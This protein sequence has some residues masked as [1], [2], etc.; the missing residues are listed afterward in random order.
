MPQL[1][2]KGT[3]KSARTQSSLFSFFTTPK[4]NKQKAADRDSQDALLDQADELMDEDMLDEVE[5]A[6]KLMSTPC[7]R[8]RKAAV[9][10]ADNDMDVDDPLGNSCS[11][12]GDDD[13]DD[14]YKP[15]TVP[16]SQSRNGRS[17]RRIVEDS[18]DE[19]EMQP[20]QTPT[21]SR[22]SKVSS[23][24]SAKTPTIARMR[25]SNAGSSATSEDLPLMSSLGPKSRPALL[26]TSTSTLST[27]ST[28]SIPLMQQLQSPPRTPT[29]AK[30]ARA[31]AFAKK[32]EERYAWLEDPRDAQGLRPGDSGYDKRTLL[33]PKAAWDKFSP[34]ERQ[35]W[36]IKCQHWDTVVFFKKGKF[37]E[38]YENDATIAHQDF[39]LKMTD[40]VNMRMA[41]V[42]ESSFDHWVAQFLAKG[43]RVARVDQKESRLAKE[44][45]ERGSTKKGDS[46]VLRELTGVLTAGTLVDPS[47]LTQDLATYCM[48]LVEEIH[49]DTS[50]GMPV[51]SFGVAFVDTSTAQF[52]LC[53][54]VDDDADRSGLETL[55]VQINP[56]EVVYVRGGAG[57]GT[58]AR[59]CSVEDAILTSPDA[60]DGMAGIS[61]ATW[62]VLKHTCA[63]TTDWISMAP[64]SE[65]WD[66][67]ASRR[68]IDNASYFE[69]WPEALQ[70]AADKQPL[71]LSAVGG[72]LSYL[73]TLKLDNDLASLGNF[74]FYS[75]M[76]HS[77]ALVLDG[78]SLANLDIFRVS[79]EG[80]SGST[81]GHA[82]EDGTLFA[83]LNHAR[84]PFGRRLLNRWIC[85]PLRH[86]SAI[87]ARLDAVEFLMG[88]VGDTI[89]EMLAGLPDL[90]R[91]LSR[92]HA[93]RCKVP[94][95]LSMLTGLGVASSIVKHLCELRSS[96]LPA[97]VQT[98]TTIFPELDE[99]LAEFKSAF[100][101]SVAETES[102]LLPF[103]GS[104]APY[105]EASATV[106]E[107][108]QWLDQHLREVC[109]RVGCKNITYRH[110][111][112]EQYQLEV[113][114]SVEVPSSYFMLSGT[115]AV[116]RYWSPE[117]RAKVQQR[118]E[119][120][121]T[122][123][124]VLDSY[125]AR[126]YSS[127]DRHY[128][129]TMKAVSVIAEIDCLLALATASRALGAPAC[130]PTVLD[131]TSAGGYIEFRQLRHPCV[132]LGGATDFVANDIVL[133]RRQ[134]AVANGT[135]AGQQDSAANEKRT[136]PQHDDPAS[137]I[138][139]TG[140][141]MGGKSTLLRQLCLGV[142]MAQIGCHVPAQ[143]AVITPVD[144][145]FTRIGA[146]DSLLAG[147]STFM[148]EMAET[149]AIVR[150]ATPRSLV[151]LDELG[152][153]TST[154]DGEAVAFAVL[155]TLCARL[156]C[157][158][159]FSTHYGLLAD[160]LL[161][162]SVEPHLRPMHMAC[163]VDEREH[164]VT[165]LY[166]LQHGIASKSHGMNVAAMAG[167]PTSIV[168]R[169]SAVAEQFEQR[170][171][172]K[173]RDGG[174]G[175]DCLPLALQSD[176]ANLMRV[177]ALAS[178]PPAVPDTHGPELPVG[179]TVCAKKANENQFWSCIVDHM[180]RTMPQL[181]NQHN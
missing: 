163:A 60:R 13:A 49:E 66:V 103:E 98:L 67:P 143:S 3:P 100:D 76:Q 131:D 41:G 62:R 9:V 27:A 151:V 126:L 172:L 177:A 130:R 148:V 86:A 51:T 94:D 92:I 119:A 174:A 28:S 24:T 133:G 155:H 59:S 135:T 157:L 72:L 144:R 179:G 171:K 32:N 123:T 122:R 109:K 56:R 181:D 127:F 101:M 132:A 12:D 165:F 38:L 1:D 2:S 65:F 116:R 96:A 70:T 111:G 137:M 7:G 50:T 25:Y 47:L 45:R 146:R 73:R 168:D 11:D 79:A 17:R 176:F 114:I 125:Q 44:M 175:T 167:V 64:R 10:D 120:V 113:P 29:E 118:A 31:S 39:D 160:A 142:I 6:E 61:Q 89:V 14:D 43:Y 117:L 102:R 110:I 152:R 105:D 99:L 104:D 69:A 169:A 35:Y 57:F 128:G 164:R 42:P 85:H 97:R 26:R 129:V 63:A 40:R 140:P 115:K 145:L 84:T 180:L 78:P 158:G 55:L 15:E 77:T 108:D 136:G 18:D 74:S 4:K 124:M 90:E 88:D 16:A 166:R 93:G 95:F 150:H 37:Y 46:L 156:G 134:D 154:H 36:E 147:R 30:R 8:K 20:P 54:I 5:Q 75:P 58:L 33:V 52:N 83:L 159:I 178:D 149:A 22:Q 170:L 48:A 80:G 141:N 162:S 53:T 138:L 121:E 71:S 19:D 23:G 173:H 112:K 81:K 107:I 139:L 21:L 87:N 82:A 91:T 68:E 153:G 106:S 161:R 34:F